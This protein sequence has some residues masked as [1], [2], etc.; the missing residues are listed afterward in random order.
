[1]IRDFSYRQTDGPDCFTCYMNLDGLCG[2]DE[3]GLEAGYRCGLYI[4]G[5]NHERNSAGGRGI[6]N[7]GTGPGSIGSRTGGSIQGHDADRV[8]DGK[9]YSS[10]Y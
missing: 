2:Y 10:G 7:Q 4:Q 5:K 3:K 6:E 9:H 8:E 1:M